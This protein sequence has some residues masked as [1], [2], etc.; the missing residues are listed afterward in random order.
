MLHECQKSLSYRGMND[1]LSSIKGELRGM[2]QALQHQTYKTW[3]DGTVATFCIEGEDAEAMSKLLKHAFNDIRSRLRAEEAVLLSFFHY[4]GGVSLQSEAK[5]L[6]R[7]LLHQMLNQNGRAMKE[8]V[9]YYQVQHET[10]TAH[11]SA[12]WSLDQLQ[13]LFESS[14][15]EILQTRHVWLF[16]DRP[17]ELE[18]RDAKKLDQQLKNVSYTPSGHRFHYCYT[19][20]PSTSKSWSETLLTLPLPKRAQSPLEPAGGF[21]LRN[22][23][24]HNL[25]L[26][27]SMEIDV[28]RKNALSVFKTTEKQ[29]APPPLEQFIIRPANVKISAFSTKAIEIPV[30]HH[31]KT[32]RIKFQVD[33]IGP[34]TIDIT[35]Q[36]QTQT[37]VKR[38][39][40]GRDVL[41]A[42]HVAPRLLAIFPF[43]NPSSWM[44][45]A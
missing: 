20:Y 3:A 39:S 23:T 29:G 35:G 14:L 4:R 13:T 19:S 9:K 5:G 24:P 42:I 31:S 17:G 6:Y 28:P 25:Q 11:H 1:R 15:I 45:G 43:A 27:G 38:S 21:V 34:F 16:I 30:S 26:S 22:W 2:P 7:T 44:T 32:I 41:V 37:V 10:H 40:D 12:V 36:Q 8:V 18:S 33:R